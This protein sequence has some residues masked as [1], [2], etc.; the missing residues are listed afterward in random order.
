MIE[1]VTDETVSAILICLMFFVAF[2]GGVIGMLQIEN[3]TTHMVRVS[4]AVFDD[5]FQNH[6]EFYEWLPEAEDFQAHFQTAM[7]SAYVYGR[8]WAV[9]TV[10]TCQLFY[11]IFFALC[12]IISTSGMS[13]TVLGQWS[14]EYQRPSLPPNLGK[15]PCF[16]ALRFFSP[17]FRETRM[18]KL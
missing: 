17:R 4:G 18:L 3:E 11:P 8:D 10:S 15:F 9:K 5:V 12:I 13:A 2:V 1:G 16:S 14:S 6:P 7:E